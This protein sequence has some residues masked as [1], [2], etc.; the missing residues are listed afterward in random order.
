MCQK[1]ETG[2]LESN[3]LFLLVAHKLL[4]ALSASLPCTAASVRKAQSEPGLCAHFV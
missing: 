1:A 3:G 4:Q 2:D